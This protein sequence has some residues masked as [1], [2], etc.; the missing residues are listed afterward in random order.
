MSMNLFPHQGTT[1]EWCVINR[2]ICTLVL[3]SQWRRYACRAAVNVEATG[4]KTLGVQPY[5]NLVMEPYELSEPVLW[6][7]LS[8][9]R[10]R[11]ASRISSRSRAT[12][13]GEEAE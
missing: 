8:D 6:S 4:T 3:F 7:W 2:L 12:A 11:S 10:R 5:S 1:T 9:T 13:S